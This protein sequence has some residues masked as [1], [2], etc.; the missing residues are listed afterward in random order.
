MYTYLQL[1]HR[2]T[3]QTFERQSRSNYTLVKFS[4]KAGRGDT[5]QWEHYTMCIIVLDTRRQIFRE[6]LSNIKVG[7]YKNFQK[8]FHDSLRDYT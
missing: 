6:F 4:K 3:R 1:A 7:H 5:G 2:P 8:R